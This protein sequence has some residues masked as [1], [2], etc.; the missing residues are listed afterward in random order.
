MKRQQIF[1]VHGG[2]VHDTYAE[3]LADLRSEK[4]DLEEK[5]KRPDG[6]KDLLGK[7]LGRNFEII[8]PPMPTSE[9]AKYLEWKI[10]FEKFIPH[11]KNGVIFIG[12]SLGGIFLAEYLAENDLKKQVK[13][14]ILV[15][16]PYALRHEKGMADFG[17]PAVLSRIERQTEKVVLYHS[18]DDPIVPFSAM[19]KYAKALPCA[20]TRVFKNRGHF[21]GIKSFPEMV[22]EIKKIVV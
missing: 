3:Y 14:L 18:V 19:K 20:E 16:A 17:L 22:R 1:I 8:Y 7:K 4:V 21:N 2:N 10:K 12:H 5:R 13:A 9:N 11:L 6:W 15:A